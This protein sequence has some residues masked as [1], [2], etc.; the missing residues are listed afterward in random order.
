MTTHKIR[1]KTFSNH[2]PDTERVSITYTTKHQ[3]TNN[4]ANTWAKDLNRE[5]SNGD[6]QMAK[7]NMKIC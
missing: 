3:K 6:I 1:K 2:V 4:P 7:K 5:F